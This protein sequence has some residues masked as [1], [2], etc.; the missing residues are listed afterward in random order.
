VASADSIGDLSFSPDSEIVG[1]NDDSLHVYTL[2]SRKGVADFSFTPPGAPVMAGQL[3]FPSDSRWSALKSAVAGVNAAAFGRFNQIAQ[4]QSKDGRDWLLLPNLGYGLLVVEAGPTPLSDASFADVIWHPRGAYAVRA[5]PGSSLAVI[6]DRD[7]YAHLIDLSRIDEREIDGTPTVGL[8][9]TAAAAIAANAPDPRILWT[10]EDSIAAG[11]GFIPPIV[12]PETGFMISAE[13][14]TRKMRVHSI[15]DPQLWITADLGNPRGPQSIGSVVPLG[16]EPPDGVLP[17]SVVASDCRASLGVFRV[18]ARLPGSMNESTIASLDVAVESEAVPGVDTPQTPEPYPPA[19]LRFQDRSANVDTRFTGDKVT[20]KRT[21]GVTSIPELRYQKGWNRFASDWIVAIADPRAS[22]EYVWPSS[23]DKT[24]AGCFSCDRPDYLN[25]TGV[26]SHEIYTAGRFLW[27]RPEFS[28]AGGYAFMKENRRLTTRISTVR[29]DLVR[30]SDGISA[31]DK[32]AAKNLPTAGAADEGPVNLNTGEV[33]QSAVDLAIQGRGLDFVMQRHYSSAIAHI[34]PFGRNFDSP[35]FARVQQMHNG[36]VI[37]FDGTGRR[38]IFT[39]GTTPPEG[40]FLDM[41]RDTFGNIAVHYPDNTRMHFDGLGRLSRIIDRNA[42]K[43][44]GSDGNTMSFM[45][46]GFGRLAAV[47]DPT[48]HR[49]VFLEYY[50]SGSCKGCVSKVRD[51]DARE[52]KYF[53]DASGRLE[54]VEG[55]DPASASSAMPSTTYTWGPAATVATKAQLYAS[56]QLES[57]KDGLSRT[58]WTVGYDPTNRWAAKTLTSG[59]GTWTFTLTPASTDVVNPNGHIFKHARDD[60]GRITALTE[61]G[62]AITTY[63]FDGEGRPA[64]IKRPMGDETR[65]GY[66]GGAGRRSMLNVGTI[67]EVPRAGSPERIA[68]MTRVTSIGY[69]PANLPTSIQHPDN[70]QTLIERDARGNPKKIV[71]GA[72]TVTTTVYDQHGLL[73]SSNDPRLGNSTFG[74]ETS[75]VKAGYLKTATKPDGVTQYGTD[76]RGN[77]TSI[78][79]PTG[80]AM[81]YTV[82]KLDQIERFQQGASQRTFTF[83]AAGHPV[84]DSELVADDPATGPVYNTTTYGVDAMGRVRTTSKN[85]VTRQYGYDAAGNVTSSTSPVEPLTTY[86]YDA[87]NRLTTITEAARVT[88]YVHD[89]GG[90]I[91]SMTDPRGHTTAFSVSGFNDEASATNSLGVVRVE[92]HDMMGRSV[93]TRVMKVPATGAMQLLRWSTREYDPAGRV[94][95]EVRKLFT[96]PLVVPPTG[97]PSGATDVVT[98]YEYDDERRTVTEID[99]RGGRSVVEHDELERP[100]K[101][102]DPAGNVLERTYLPNGKVGSETMTEVGANGARQVTKRAFHYDRENRLSEAVDDSDPARRLVRSYVRDVRGNV[103]KEIDPAGRVT[104]FAYDVRANKISQID[105]DGGQTRFEYDSETNRLMAVVDPRGGRTEYTYDTF[106]NVATETRPGGATWTYVYDANNNLTTVTDP[107][108][109]VTTHE[110][111]ADDRWVGYAISRGTGVGGATSVTV[112]LDG[113]GRPIATATNE[114]VKTFHAWDSLD[115]ELL[116]EMEIAN[117][118]RRRIGRSFDS[119]GNVI[120][121]DYPSGLALTYERDHVGQIAAIRQTA[122]ADPIVRYGYVGERILSKATSN[123]TMQTRSYDPYRRVTELVDRVSGSALRHS[124]YERSTAGDKVKVTRTAL[125]SFDTFAYNARSRIVEEKLRTPLDPAIVD[126][127]PEVVTLYDPDRN[128]NY[129]S[130]TTYNRTPAGTAV[131]AIKT[132]TDARNQYTSF[133]AETLGYDGNGNVISRASGAMQL[134]YDFRNR[135]VRATGPSG[136]VENL[137]DANGVKVQETRRTAAG[138]MTREYIHQ[139]GRLLEEYVNGTLDARYVRG[140]DVDEI[141]RAEQSTAGNGTLDLIVYP[142]QDELGNV[143]LLADAAG[144][145]LERYAFDGYGK[146]H[147][148]GQDGQELPASAYGWR[149]LFQG[150]E[151]VSILG[152][153]DFRARVLWP[154][155]GRFNSEDPLGQAPQNLYAAFDGNWQSKRDPDGLEVTIDET[156]PTIDRGRLLPYNRKNGT[157]AHKAWQIWVRANRRTAVALGRN[158]YTDN[159]IKTIAGDLGIEPFCCERTR[160]DAAR[161]EHTD[162][163]TLWELK[164]ETYDKS[165]FNSAGS[166]ALLAAAQL[167]KYRTALRMKATLGFG[168]ELNKAHF[169]HDFITVI[170]GDDGGYRMYAYSVSEARGMIYYEL[171]A[172]KKRKKNAAEKAFEAIEEMEKAA[173][174]Y[175][176][177]PV[178]GF[179]PG[180]APVPVLIR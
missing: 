40:V 116:T 67:T 24:A 61:P 90:A 143:E 11:T 145:S 126:P 167:L 72:G 6:L 99:P 156:Y 134:Q 179:A 34:G 69:G 78:V 93:D 44:D 66:S 76:S 37:F 124:E 31:L 84:A 39:G 19:H 95:K 54:R 146:F 111:D 129:D 17:C 58:V 77:R 148:F 53:Y 121:V 74:Y 3:V 89:D 51:Y 169:E 125:G 91:V 23:A 160:P 120:G 62:G 92:T 98:T 132:I 112:T 52:V 173:A 128:L 63:S 106:G 86:G 149:W 109:T 141:V 73:K 35:L 177:I 153:Y 147:V 45:Y 118:T 9:P 56:G 151:Y 122:A 8:F 136:T 123:S 20:L 87:R 174:K 101:I 94:L 2:D 157:A 49:P 75:G 43:T 170:P 70:S 105:P 107:N 18:E 57:E 97:D 178:G 138:T 88:T 162:S 42:T 137:Y 161:L 16:V 131:D 80:R 28:S 119:T 135:L 64:S 172:Q 29:G 159:W 110:Y 127:T 155:L 139:D 15:I 32:V 59:G 104:T 152:A 83:N 115:R 48:G 130:I 12:D 60:D 26:D 5:I 27:V 163:V 25:A 176:I 46:D 144:E 41:H 166:R 4:F 14:L 10:S 96:G 71:D 81:T 50:N 114:G 133:G 142:V 82:N 154:D 36:D 38:D 171:E 68:N 30:P 13:L 21:L 85:G 79:D 47:V 33:T 108:G 113:A 158:F 150:R 102:T 65:Y 7:G 180:G 117:G 165:R 168:S 140:T 164:P 175:G 103:V 100:V 1:V 55:P 22:K